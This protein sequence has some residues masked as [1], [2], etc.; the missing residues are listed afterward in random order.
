MLEIDEE[1]H[2]EV[3]SLTVHGAHQINI[4]DPASFGRLH[5][6]AMLVL[7]EVEETFAFHDACIRDN[8]IHLTECLSRLPKQSLYIGPTRDVCGVITGP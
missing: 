5:Q 7:F 3:P 4:D 2:S 1:R 6:V 8:D